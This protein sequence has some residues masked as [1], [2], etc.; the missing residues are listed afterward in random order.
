MAEPYVLEGTW[1]E[2]VPQAA[3]LAG[4]GRRMK[5]ILPSDESGIS[6][7][8]NA[9]ALSLLDEWLMED[10]MVAPGEREDVNWEWEEFR[11]NLEA[12]PAAY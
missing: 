5:L 9:T 7:P 11:A 2:L 1:E 12:H 4:S 3:K 6:L 10:Q 8:D